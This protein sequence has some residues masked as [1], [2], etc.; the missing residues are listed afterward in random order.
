MP[1]QRHHWN[2]KCKANGFLLLLNPI[3]REILTTKE[4]EYTWDNHYKHFVVGAFCLLK[5]DL[6]SPVLK[7]IHL[8]QLYCTFTFNENTIG[9][10]QTGQYV[11]L[12]VLIIVT[13]HIGVKKQPTNTVLFSC[14]IH[15]DGSA[16]NKIP[17]FSCGRVP[18]DFH[19]CLFGQ[20]GSS[21]S[22]FYFF[23]CL[24]KTSSS[25]CTVL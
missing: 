7:V 18:L 20:Q 21:F 6:L 1:N 22:S 24:C 8:V 14:H 12:K 4:P 16:G 13:A 10:C 5:R 23:L 11:L 19:F 2:Y 3:W 15:T 25:L 17:S 9:S